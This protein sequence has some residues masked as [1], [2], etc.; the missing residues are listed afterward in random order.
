[1]RSRLGNFYSDTAKLRA[2]SDTDRLGRLHP[3][4]KRACRPSLQDRV[5]NLRAAPA[6]TSAVHIQ[7]Y[8]SF[9]LTLLLQIARAERGETVPA[10]RAIIGGAPRCQGEIITGMFTGRSSIPGLTNGITHT[11]NKLI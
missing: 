1:M 10:K 7:G 9:L 5:N 6:P 3:E 2:I 11:F 4:E 8:P